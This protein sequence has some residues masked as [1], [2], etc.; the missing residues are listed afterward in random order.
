MDENVQAAGRVYTANGRLLL[1]K[2]PDGA[3]GIVAGSCE[4][5]ETAQQTA[6]RESA[7]EIGCAPEGKT[8]WSVQMPRSDGP[9]DFRA[10]AVALEQDFTPRLNDEHTGWGWFEGDKLPSPLFPGTA[11]IL[12][13]FTLDMGAMCRKMAEGKYTSPQR[14]MN[15]TLF[16]MRISGT[17]WAYRGGE[18]REYA[19]RNRDDWLTPEVMEACQGMPVVLDHPDTSVVTDDFYRGRSVGS[20]VYP[21]IKGDEL[22]AIT[23]I[24][25]RR[26]ATVLSHEPWS[27][28]PGVISGKDS[29]SRPLGE[30][31]TT[32]L[33]EGTPYHPD[34]LALVSA[35]VWDKYGPPSGID[36][37]PTRQHGDTPPMAK[38]KE[39]LPSARDALATHCTVAQKDAQESGDADKSAVFSKLLEE[40]DKIKGLIEGAATAE[41]D[42]QGDDARPDDT[43]LAEKLRSIAQQA[44]LTAP[45]EAKADED[46]GSTPPM[47]SNHIPGNPQPEQTDA[48]QEPAAAPADRE[49]LA[50]ELTQI[51]QDAMTDTPDKDKAE[52]DTRHDAEK[53][54]PDEGRTEERQDGA[55]PDA[56]DTP[57]EKKDRKDGV[58]DPASAQADRKDEGNAHDML[59][60][61]VDAM[62]KGGVDDAAIAQCITDC[63]GDPQ[64]YLPAENEEN[65]RIREQLAEMDRRD[66]ER[67]DELEEVKSR[68]KPLSD[69]EHNEISELQSRTDAVAQPLGVQTPRYVPGETVAGYGRRCAELL[70]PH[71]KEWATTNLAGLTPEVFAIASRQ[72]HKDAQEAAKR[73]TT[74]ADNAPI[75]A[76]RQRS[77]TGHSRTEYRGSFRAGFGAFMA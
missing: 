21:F 12:D 69:E 53:E 27:T 61:M 38:L 1:L 19:Y 29:I 36:A 77:D 58:I 70:K 9:G 40:L 26:L 41:H 6:I 24:Q 37:P 33:L 30:D 18:R 39:A 47:P 67:R 14:F 66:Q 57:E 56:P 11:D 60:K 51:A 7:E 48:T 75:Q 44:G 13:R 22:W 46:T 52:K 72:I 32:L 73:P 74:Y 17:G 43:A 25:D 8:L 2:R 63:G 4:D 28:S 34:H 5:G 3:W 42:A 65:R 20:V 62:R 23:R 68:T 15:V 54:A 64:A 31:G 35:G 16:A 55:E 50:D 76:I 71:S 59:A 10:Y 49:G 45:S